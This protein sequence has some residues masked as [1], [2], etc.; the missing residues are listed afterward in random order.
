MEITKK[1]IYL[2]L[3]L[4]AVTG[5]GIYL[6]S[7]RL[8]KKS[9]I[10]VSVDGETETEEKDVCEDKESVEETKDEFR[11]GRGGRGFG[12][13]GWGGYGYGYPVYG[14]WGGNCMVKDANGTM[15]VAPC[16]YELDI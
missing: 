10:K 11:G 13:R 4:L 14:G 6:Y 7:N 2:G 8:P 3:G 1:H 16:G 12:R 15:A 9:E 5:L